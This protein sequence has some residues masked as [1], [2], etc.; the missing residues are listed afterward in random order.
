M[1]VSYQNIEF[2]FH[3]GLEGNVYVSARHSDLVRVLH[4]VLSEIHS[5]EVELRE[6]VGRLV[7]ALGQHG[8]LVG[9]I[10]GK[11][12][13]VACVMT[14]KDEEVSFLYSGD[15]YTTSFTGFMQFPAFI[16]GS[17]S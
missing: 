2:S 16:D 1:S 13:R 7:V 15:W 11:G 10:E 12:A 14:T 4:T 9:G 6:I 8:P 5:A 17:T 3:D